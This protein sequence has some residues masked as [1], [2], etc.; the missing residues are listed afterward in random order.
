MCLNEEYELYDKYSNQIIDSNDFEPNDLILFHGS[1][2]VVTQPVYGYGNSEND[3][4]VG[5][6]LTEDFQQAAEWASA[7][8][9]D[10]GTVNC[11]RVPNG[12]LG[13]C[14]DI[15]EAS[16]LYWIT[17]LVTYRHFAG[18]DVEKDFLQEHFFLD[19]E[20]YDVIIAYRCDD[21]YFDM[22]KS[23]LDGELS[24]ESLYTVL[25]AGELGFQYVMKSE[26]AHDMLEFIKSVEVGNVY[27]ETYN[28]KIAAANNIVDEQKTQ[29]RTQRRKGECVILHDMIDD[30][31]NG[32]D[33]LL[34]YYQ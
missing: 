34:R 6:Y 28:K 22:A 33:T 14:L 13:N 5:F 17:M 15:T 16:E 20:S 27:A 18:F 7:M 24:L 9:G 21:S 25:T 23:F 12:N 19:I 8:Y 1:N 4:G 3:A 26:Y 32:D 11:Y 31:N 2:C 10:L 30:Y 29:T